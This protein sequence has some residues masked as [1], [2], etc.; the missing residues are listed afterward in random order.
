MKIL[1]RLSQATKA[2]V[3]LGQ[4]LEQWDSAE[5]M[6]LSDDLFRTVDLFKLDLDKLFTI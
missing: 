3:E 1:L 5:R 2:V 4:R 6:V